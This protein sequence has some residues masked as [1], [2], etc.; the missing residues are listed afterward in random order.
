MIDQ[1]KITDLINSL[2]SADNSAV[3]EEALKQTALVAMCAPRMPDNC[4]FH[5]NTPTGIALCVKPRIILD[6]ISENSL[7]KDVNSKDF[8]GGHCRFD[9]NLEFS[10]FWAC[11]K[12]LDTAASRSEYIEY[13]DPES[14]FQTV[15]PERDL[16]LIKLCFNWL[17]TEIE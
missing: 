14:S 4:F 16:D 15:S 1:N 10:E 3:I 5:P 6:W 9:L 2:R 12:V 11:R 7:I 17:E 8:E 13:I